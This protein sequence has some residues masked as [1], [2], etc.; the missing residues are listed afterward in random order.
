MAHDMILKDSIEAETG[1]ASLKIVAILAGGVLVG[2]SYIV[3]YLIKDEG[4]FYRD[5]LAL[6]GAVLLGAPVIGHAIKHLLHGHMHMDELVAV[7]ILAAF[8]TGQYQVAGTVGFFL[9]LA[10]L[11]ESRTALGAKASIESLVRLAPKKAHKVVD[12]NEQLVD[13]NSLRGR[14]RPR[15]PGRQYS[16][17]WRSP[18]R[19]DLHQPG[20]HHR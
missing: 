2:I 5:T 8:A 16:R 3:G 13:P 19:P 7:A 20:E 17:R 15:P 14:H 9:L 10:N 18:H 6:L 4:G 12:G 11:V 1:R